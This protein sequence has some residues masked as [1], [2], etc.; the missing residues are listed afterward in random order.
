[1]TAVA[2]VN[3]L[4]V[5]VTVVKGSPRVGVKDVI[6]GAVSTVKLLE[7][8]ALPAWLATVI[9]PV[10][11]PVGTTAVIEV[12]EVTVELLDKTP[13]NLTDVTPV[14]PVP[15]TVTVVPG[16]PWVG[17]KDE[18]VGDLEIETVA[19]ADFVGSCRLVAVTV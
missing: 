18:M 8:V 3:P 5:R 19:E 2:P 16:A 4:P 6:V 11:A 13:L 7:L 10:V 9:P 15:V 1:M 14:S 17:A 12:S